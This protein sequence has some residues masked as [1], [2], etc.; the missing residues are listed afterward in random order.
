MTYKSFFILPLILL[1]SCCLT[2]AFGQK[3]AS[4]FEF[5]YDGKTLR[6][7]IEQP[8]DRAPSAVIVLIPGYGRTN[9]VQGNWYASL[10]DQFVDMGLAVC[11]W[12]K[13]G[14]GDSEG[15]FD[16]D[17]PVQSSAQEGLAA[18]QVLQEQ[19][20]F[21]SLKI[22]LWG[23][24]RAGWI[25]PLIIDQH[26]IDFWISASGTDDK[27]TYGY[28]L[29]SNLIIH[30][31]SEAEAQAL[32]EAWQ[33]GHQLFCTG[34]SYEEAE[35]A[36]APLKQD[37]LCRQLFGYKQETQGSEAG[38]KAYQEA[39]RNFTKNGHF[40]AQ[41]GLWVYISDFATLLSRID[42]PVLAF[43]GQQD[44]QVDWRRTKALYE[45]TLG[46]R[47]P[48]RLTIKTLSTCN[49]NIQKCDTCGMG[50]DLSKYGWQ[51]CDGYYESMRQ[52]LKELELVADH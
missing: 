16:A 48:N 8:L 34:G 13:M 30:G 4:K 3:Q 39:Q 38:R 33:K 24:S 18:L 37:S 35:L 23:L 26:P 15:V 40:D 17:Q 6:G 10:R 27:E 7:L 41:S 29:R 44:S 1:A 31:K 9:F 45:K 32:Y 25:C 51:A 2:V 43:F 42:C 5:Q 11:F 46:N 49:H 12:D 14:C 52:W 28:L 50:E 22:G 20:Q 47:K 19:E 36:I 21:S